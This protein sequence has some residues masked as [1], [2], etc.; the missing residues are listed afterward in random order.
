MP[1]GKCR[2]PPWHKRL[3]FKRGGSSGG[4]SGNGIE[5]TATANKSV[6]AKYTTGGHSDVETIG[7]AGSPTSEKFKAAAERVSKI[8]GM[9]LSEAIQSIESIRSYTGSSDM[10]G[11]LRSQQIS[12]DANSK[13]LPVV[14]GINRYIAKMPKYQGE[15]HR[16]L[17]FKTK[18]EAQSFLNQALSGL[19]LNSNASFSSSKSYSENFA[20]GNYGVVLTVKQNKSGVSVRPVSRTPYENEVLAPKDVKYKP[21]AGQKIVAKKGIV[22][23]EVEED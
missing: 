3:K 16:G 10:P 4:G 2:L 17:S 23:V 20:K 13:L 8:S 1:I 11:K 14:D 5:T 21:I 15:I 7:A 18:A 19:S 12:P 6:E 22:Y 9:S